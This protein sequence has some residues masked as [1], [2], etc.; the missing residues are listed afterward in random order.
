MQI[1]KETVTRKLRCDSLF[2]LLGELKNRV[3]RRQTA[4]DAVVMQGEQLVRLDI[5]LVDFQ[6]YLRTDDDS[7]ALLL[8]PFD[9]CELAVVERRPLLHNVPKLGIFFIERFEQQPWHALLFVIAG[10]AREH[11]DELV[12]ACGQRTLVGNG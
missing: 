4:A 10:V 11:D 1:K 2:L 7:L 8:Q 9:L 5:E 6:R 3:E 12:I